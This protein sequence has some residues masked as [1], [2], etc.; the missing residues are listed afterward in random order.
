MTPT[1][2]AGLQWE[3]GANVF[4]S[5]EFNDDRQ[6]MRQAAARLI[7]PYGVAYYCG[8][9]GKPSE[10]SLAAPSRPMA[11]VRHWQPRHWW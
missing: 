10:R 5:T 8:V 2:E 1:Y 7:D 9:I 3:H 11:N 6:V 4:S